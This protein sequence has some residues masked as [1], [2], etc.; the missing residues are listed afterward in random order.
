MINT[1]G[2]EVKEVWE[3]G[4]HINNNFS[5]ISFTV[6]KSLNTREHGWMKQITCFYV[7]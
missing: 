7:T 6:S 3:G 4:V 5:E 1:E 2:Y